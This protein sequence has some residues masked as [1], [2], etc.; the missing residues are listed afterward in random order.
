M[1]LF[2]ILTAAILIPLVGCA[3][4]QGEKMKDIRVETSEE[5][6]AGWR[7]EIK[8]AAS[9]M[10]DL[11]TEEGQQLLK[12]SGSKDFAPLHENWVAQLKSHCG[13]ASA[14]VV[15]NA[16]QPDAEYTQSGLFTDE[17]AHIITQ[18]VV[19]RIGFTLEELENM[20]ET[21]S[22]LKTTRFHAGKTDEFHSYEEWLEALKANN[23]SADNNLIIN[24]PIYYM[25]TRENKGGHFSPIAAYHEEKNMVLILE[26][27]ARRGSYWVDAMDVWEAMNEV[28]SVSGLNRGWI[29]VEQPSP[30]V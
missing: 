22:G 27:N 3:H 4:S 20:I 26:I 10:V 25:I 16:M 29:V 23:S 24:Y 6:V 1:K 14:C 19:Y 5:I 21:R 12:E 8:D 11:E 15:Q 7:E 30:K 13:A 17:T 9:I 18:D 28:D 2:R